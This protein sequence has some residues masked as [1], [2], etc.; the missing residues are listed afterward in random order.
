MKLLNTSVRVSKRSKTKGRK[1]LP[2]RTKVEPGDPGCEAD[3]SAAPWSIKRVLKK[4]KKLRN[5][6]EQIRQHPKGRTRENSPGI[7]QVESDDLD[8]EA[9]ELA[10]SGSVEDVGKRPKKLSNT[11]ECERKRS[12][13]R[14]RQHSPGRPGEEPDEPGGETVV[15]GDVQSPPERHRGGTN[16]NGIETKPSSLDTEPRHHLGEPEV[17]RGVEGVRDRGTVVDDAEHDQTCPRADGSERIV[18]TNTPCR[19][20]RPGGHMGEP[21][22]SR[23]AEGDWSRKSDVD[24]V[25]YNGRRDG[26]DGATSSARCDSKRVETRLLAGEK[27]QYQQVERDITTDVPEASTPPPNDPRRPV[28]LPNPPRRRGRIKSRSEKIRRTKM[29]KLTYRIVQPRRGQSGR[30]KRIR[31][32]AYEVQMLGEPIPARYRRSVTLQRSRIQDRAHS[33]LPES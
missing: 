24:G 28:E 7:P 14:S 6:S 27:G 13:R 19:R 1:Y 16:D 21:K 4:P 9:V 2:G 31:D 23:D 33:A 5:V 30:I 3:A 12:K 15:Q 11:S 20:N 17:S 8:D 10:T 25:G 26:K 29:K 18:K 32:V 22:A